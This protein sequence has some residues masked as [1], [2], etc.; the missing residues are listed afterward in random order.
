M[1]VSR[2]QLDPAAE[3]LHD[4]RL[5]GSFYSRSE[6]TA[7]W[8]LRMPRWDGAHYHVVAQGSCW[9]RMPG[10]PAQRLDAGDLVVLPH[11]GGH[12]LLDDP[13]TEAEPVEQLSTES[14]GKSAAVL[15]YG[16]GGPSSLVICGGVRFEPHPL[17][18]LLPDVLIVRPGADGIEP[19]VAATVEALM[20][21]AAHPRA[22]TETV[23][24]RLSDVLV[25]GAVRSWLETS[26]DARDGWLGALRDERI[27]AAL[28]LM[29]RG[30]EE[31][32]TVESLAARVGMSR[33]SFAEHFTEL[34][35]ASP[36]HYL[37]RLRMQRATSWIR[38]DKLSLSEAANRLGYS[39]SAAFSRA[40]KRHMG[41]APGSVRVATVG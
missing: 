41:V 37:T 35:R 6:L 5:A 18:D 20:H 36:M 29:H 39:S 28:A 9:V 30:T 16:G 7:P 3:V 23:I 21:E 2:T 33:A 17:V 8:G 31:P 40:F 10:G 38:D 1:S 4:L 25:I 15:R 26:A 24:T 13:D 14:I 19:W 22:G 32:W 34:V 11:G 12:E 27:G